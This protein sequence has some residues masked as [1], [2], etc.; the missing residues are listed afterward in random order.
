MDV[1]FALSISK[2][3]QK[4]NGNYNQNLLALVPLRTVP[5][6]DQWIQLQS[7]VSTYT[8]GHDNMTLSL[9]TV[10]VC[11]LNGKYI[12]PYLLSRA[13]SCIIMVLLTLYQMLG[14]MRSELWRVWLILHFMTQISQASWNSY[15][16]THE[17]SYL[18]VCMYIA[19]YKFRVRNR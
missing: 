14:I 1:L 6:A 10:C 9:F 3:A 15:A 19:R 7:Y 18:D 17:Q 12:V 13:E 8:C 11:G 2:C 16:Q 4:S 5:V